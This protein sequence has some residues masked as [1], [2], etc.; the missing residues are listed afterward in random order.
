MNILERLN[1]EKIMAMIRGVHPGVGDR[2]VEA[3]VQ[4]GIRFLE[5][6]TNTEGVYTLV[7]RWR[8]AY[9]RDLLIG[10]G[11]V[12][13]A[14]MARQAIDAGAQ[15]IVSPNLDEEVIAYGARNQV[16]VYPGV[17]TPTEIVRAVKAGAKAVKVF[18]TGSLG[19]AAYLKEIRAPLDHV[20]MIASGSVGLHNI[21]EILEAGAFAVG[22]GGNLVN[23]HW[24]ESG[25]FVAMQKLA[26][27]LVHIVT[28]LREVR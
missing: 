19:G 3:L 21:R 2:T 15:F 10:V 4:G 22:I 1:K 16:D 27:E 13:D 14:E 24:I 11:T 12:L 23:R 5:V 20:P 26:Q 9:G 8:K 7:E 18:P 28:D 6:T 17:M 25:N